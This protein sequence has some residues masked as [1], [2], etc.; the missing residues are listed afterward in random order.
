MGERLKRL[1][2]AAGYSQDRFAEATGIPVGT[3]RNY[4]QDRRMPRLDQAVR[5]AKA[6]SI[7][8]D[9]LAAGLVKDGAVEG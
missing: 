7:T 6:L 3:L 2:R 5:M 4:E 8:L 1:R 9:A